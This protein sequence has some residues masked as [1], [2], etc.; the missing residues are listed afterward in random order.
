MLLAMISTTYSVLEAFV[1]ATTMT[2][3]ILAP[4]I[5]AV[6][7]ALFVRIGRANAMCY[8]CKAAMRAKGCVVEGM[9]FVAW[10]RAPM[11]TVADGA[12]VPLRAILCCEQKCG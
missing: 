2:V 4:G 1:A 3:P 5:A 10:S 6:L 8:D 7:A 12:A 11:G 9:V